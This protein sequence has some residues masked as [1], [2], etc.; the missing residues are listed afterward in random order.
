[1][2]VPDGIDADKSTKVLK[3]LKALYGTKQAPR[4]WNSNINELLVS[5]KFKRCSKDTCIANQRLV[6]TSSSAFSW[7]T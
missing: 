6:A 3:L 1:M 2:E 4:A 5:V 7:M